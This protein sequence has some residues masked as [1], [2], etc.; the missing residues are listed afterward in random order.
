MRIF[1]TGILLFTASFGFS[2][3]LEF[4]WETDSLFDKPES[5]VFDGKKQVIYVS[6]V[7]GQY[8]TKDGNGFISKVDLDGNILEL[9]WATGLN[10]PQGLALYGNKLYVAD[11]DEIMEIDVDQEEI[12]NKYKIDGA[13]FL[14][15][16]ASDK[17]G[18]IFV[19]DCKGNKIYKL[20]NNHVDIWSENPVLKGV[21][22]LYCAEQNLFVLNMG[23]GI[24]YKVDYQTK[25]FSEFSSGIKNCDG[26]VPDGENGFFVSG[27]WQGECYHINSSGEKSLILNLGEE[28]TIVADIDYVPEKQ[29]LLVPTLHKTLMAYKWNKK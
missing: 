1:L 5:A 19:S 15:D 29:M 27:A 12:I 21:N 7:N 16:A 18:N 25:E 14:N 10:S 8:C 20:E 11:V 6:N 3:T 2:Q 9:N 22:G 28:K 26:I 24:I 23:T 17:S 4:V 13:K